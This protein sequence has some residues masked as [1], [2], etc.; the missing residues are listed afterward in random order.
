[1]GWTYQVIRERLP[2]RPD[3]DL[4]LGMGASGR[5]RKIT[6]QLGKISSVERNEAAD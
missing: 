6:D 2:V 4:S 5:W 3:R 1:M